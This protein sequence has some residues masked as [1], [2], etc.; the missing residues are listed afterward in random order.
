MQQ[1]RSE[2]VDIAKAIGIFLVVIAHTY[3]GLV[4]GGAHFPHVL[5]TLDSVIYTFHMPLFFFISGIFFV[6][7]IEKRTLQQFFVSKLDTVAYPYWVWGTI[8]GLLIAYLSAKGI[9]NQDISYQEVFMIWKPLGQ[10]W[11]L[12]DLFFI[13]CFTALIYK[14]SKLRFLELLILIAGVLYVFQTDL[15]SIYFVSFLAKNWI[16]FLLGIYFFQSR[17]KMTLECHVWHIT[18]L[19]VFAFIMQYW[20][21]AIL[22]FTYE[23][24]GIASLILA[25]LM[26][27]MTI[28]WAYRLEGR[29]PDWI[30]LMGRHSMAIYLL[31]VFFASGIRIVGHKLLHIDQPYFDLFLGTFIAIFI[32]VRIAML[33]ESRNIPFIFSFK[34]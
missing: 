9:A 15:R 29:A 18:L 31:H 8:Q 32:P 10:F 11:F 1:S 7:S 33:V 23:V 14:F 22:H 34:H 5:S 16:F 30:L 27:L 12:H 3:R 17:L 28:K 2:W 4:D 20:F 24:K 21:H 19:T 6:K 13:M 26:S 25:I